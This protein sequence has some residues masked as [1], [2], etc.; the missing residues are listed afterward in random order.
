MKIWLFVRSLLKEA[1]Q[2][3]LTFSMLRSFICKTRSSTGLRVISASENKL[4][5]PNTAEEYNLQKQGEASVETLLVHPPSKKK[6]L[7]GPVV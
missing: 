1:F 7:E 6:K 2:I 3:L 5:S 4:K